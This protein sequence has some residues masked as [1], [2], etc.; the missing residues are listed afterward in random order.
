MI[1]KK[2][3]PELKV[4]RMVPHPKWNSSINLYVS[5]KYAKPEVKNHLFI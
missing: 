3:T 4:R 5:V 1:I 2:N